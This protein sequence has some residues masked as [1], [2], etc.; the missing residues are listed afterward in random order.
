MSYILK[1]P[2]GAAKHF[3][4]DD[5]QIK[6]TRGDLNLDG[7]P[8]KVQG[9]EIAGILN[10][11]YLIAGIVAVVAIVIGGVRYTVSGGD[12]SGVKAAKDTILYAVIGLVVIMAAA[13]ITDFVIK[14]VAK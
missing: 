7:A 9:A 4:A 11:V 6:I 3:A 12:S 5:T 10:T 13:G 14:N 1:E 8:E 2:Y